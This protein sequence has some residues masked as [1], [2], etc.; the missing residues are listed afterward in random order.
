M[1]R[2]NSEV[3]GKLGEGGVTVKK[4]KVSR[5]QARSRGVRFG[6]AETVGGL[7]KG[8]FSAEVETEVR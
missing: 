4:E 7:D 2:S 1:E 5:H 8:S 6:N 3:R